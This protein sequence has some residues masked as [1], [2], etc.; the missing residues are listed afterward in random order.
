MLKLS[1]WTSSTFGVQEASFINYMNLVL[2]LGT[3]WIIWFFVGSL[4]SDSIV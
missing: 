4:D 2:L 3:L 1:H